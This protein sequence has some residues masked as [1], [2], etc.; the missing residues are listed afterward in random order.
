M[1]RGLAQNMFEKLLEA[2]ITTEPFPHII[3][4]NFFERGTYNR[5]SEEF[6]SGRQ[7][8]NYEIA[9]EDYIAKQ[10]LSGESIETLSKYVKGITSEKADMYVQFYRKRC[11]DKSLY[12]RELIQNSAISLQFSELEAING[13]ASFKKIRDE[14]NCAKLDVI[15]KFKRWLPKN[16]QRDSILYSKLKEVSYCRGDIRVNAAVVKEGTTTLGA[17]LDSQQEIIAGLIYCRDKN[18]QGNG[19][20]LALYKLKDE[21]MEKFMSKKRRIPEKLIDLKKT[22]KYGENVAIFFPNSLKAIH[23]VTVRDINMIERRLLN[24]SIE[25]PGKMTLWRSELGV[26]ENLSKEESL[27]RY[28]WIK[29]DRAML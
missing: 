13:L 7:I 14:W 11:K 17:H 4:K 8:K 5:I 28:S 26:D 9:K 12:N 1:S 15:E 3:I 6:P 20:D 16:I 29:P 24:L 23:A 21:K 18:D 27:G 25:L 22:V 10:I 19:G 2:E